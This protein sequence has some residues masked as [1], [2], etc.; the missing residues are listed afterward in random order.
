MQLRFAFLILVAFF[1]L[2]TIEAQQP[3]LNSLQVL[4]DS[5][6]DSLLWLQDRI[7]EQQQHIEGFRIQVFMESGNDAVIKAQELIEK[8]AEDYPQ[9]KAYLSYGQPYYR[10]RLGD[11]RDRLEAEAALNQLNR[12]YKQAFITRDQIAFPELSAFPPLNEPQDE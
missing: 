10:V 2:Q 1:A 5:R 8:L 6:V 11:F 7:N 4:Q 3:A 9:W 12:S